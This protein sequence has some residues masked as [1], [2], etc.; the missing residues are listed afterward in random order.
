MENQG[1]S[2]RNLFKMGGIAATGALGAVALSSCGG[3]PSTAEQ[4]KE[5]QP[6]FARGI[7]SEDF[8]GSAAEIE[9]ITDFSDEKTYDIV[10]VGAGTSGLPAVLTALEE[11]ASVAC[12]QKESVPVS[13]GNGS[14]GL[15]LD[16]AVSNLKGLLTWAQEYRTALSYR[17]NEE[18]LDTYM[19]TSGET[20]LWM[21]KMS[22]EAGYPPAATTSQMSKHF[23]DDSFVTIVSNNFGIKPESNNDLVAAL[24][25]YAEQLGAEFFYSTPGV[26]LVTDEAGA[27]TGV[28]G[29]S[30]DGS[31]LKF[32]A[33]K[34]VILAC[35]DYQN[36]D[37][38]MKKFSPEI[39]GFARKQQ[40]KT[41]DGI[42]MGIAAGGRLCPV[43]HS[44]SLHDMD[45][46]PLF[47]ADFPLLAVG[48]DG[49]RFMNEEIPMISWNQTLR[50]QQGVEDPGRFCRIF[51]DAYE[52]KIASWGGTPTPKASMEN[53]IPGLLENPTGVRP[54]LI[55]THRCD[56]LDELAEEL[57]VPTEN[58]KES[59]ERWNEPCE[60]GFDEDFGLAEM[61]LKPIDTPPY[62][63]VRQ[64]V[65]I[66]AVHAG[67]EVNKFN[68]AL[69]ENG[70][71]IPGLYGVG[72]TGGDLCGD[73]DWS[74]YL[75]GLCCGY[76]MTSGRYAVIHALTGDIEPSSPVAWSD[77]FAAQYGVA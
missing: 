72:F 11:G 19:R 61:Y 76:C 18:M 55:D 69:D 33:A 37:S 20:M 31:Y 53:Y 12:L 14:S 49:K 21:N 29:K 22:N 16:P 58:L 60:N 74:F 47:M 46:A 2:R 32:N 43:G 56:T 50:Q 15:I 66:T 25:V 35:G 68:Q 48:M 41:G 75:G 54:D 3:Q 51:D 73:V 52:E 24:A 10:V 8:E 39:D 34:G 71:V 17:V 62:W 7:A 44:H 13:Q 45:A 27:V 36:N 4:K 42:L 65:R 40:G 30:K 5:G 63:G 26:Q 70:E 9:P 1:I 28:I 67:F 59:V 38:M 6:S 77:D 57:G 64:W 23:S